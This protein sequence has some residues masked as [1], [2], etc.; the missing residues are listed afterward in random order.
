MCVCLLQCKQ[1]L[2]L[3]RKCGELQATLG[4]VESTAKQQLQSLAHQSEAA[5]DM[6]QSKLLHT[7][8]SVKE[9]HKFISV[10]SGCGVIGSCPVL[11]QYMHMHGLHI[12]YTV[13]LYISI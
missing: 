12:L 4:A 1:A 2:D 10:S 5:I 3:Q 7:S 13:L 8:L 11:F 9:F 6:A